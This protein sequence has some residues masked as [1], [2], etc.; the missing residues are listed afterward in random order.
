MPDEFFKTFYDV[1]KTRKYI[2][3]LMCI[4]WEYKECRTR[5]V[6]NFSGTYKTKM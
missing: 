6:V 1:M 4:L 5:T 3:R 2:Y